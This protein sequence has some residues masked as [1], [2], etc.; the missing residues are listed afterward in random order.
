MNFKFQLP[1]V[2]VS[3]EIQSNSDNIL[4]YWYKEEIY[5]FKNVFITVY[6]LHTNL[7]H[8]STTASRECYH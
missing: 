8:K 1:E 6:P 5:V 3:K 2:T 4:W 7:L